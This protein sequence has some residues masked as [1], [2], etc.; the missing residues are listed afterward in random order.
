MNSRDL[1]GILLFDKPTGISS[2]GALQSEPVL[3]YDPS[4]NATTGP[5]VGSS[6]MPTISSRA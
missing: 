3:G 2:N 4:W 1:D 5:K 6:A